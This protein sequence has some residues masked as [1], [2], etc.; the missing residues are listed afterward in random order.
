MPEQPPV[1]TVIGEALIDLVPAGGPGGY[2]AQP[3][4]SPYN[5]AI[6]LARLGRRAA[7]MARLGDNAFGRLLRGHAAAEGVD[8]DYAPDAAEPTTL[9]V[10]S[11]DDA[12]QA[13]YDFYY[14]GTADWQWTGPELARVPAD[15]AALHLGS[16]AALLPPGADRLHGLVRS[17]RA[18]AD[19]KAGAP[20]ATI[21]YDPNIRPA[22]LDTV[23]DARGRVEALIALADLV[24]LS[25]ADLAWLRPGQTPEQF[26]LEQSGGPGRIAVVTLGG[27]GAVAA[28][29]E[30][31]SH[32]LPAHSVAVVDTVGAGDSYMSALLAGLADRGL[33]GAGRR[34]ALH[35]VGPDTFRGILTQAAVAAAVTC[36]RRGSN[37]PTRAEL[38]ARLAASGALAG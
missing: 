2:T 13:S 6:G 37:P 15:T 30:A 11:V 18:G 32:R 21:S 3:G 1:I 4:G 29:P 14:A 22:L 5:V 7:L 34:A 31:G 10:V 24:K 36:E 19:G 23:T 26:V 27:Q 20:G 17:I 35:G 25:D 12:A 38:Q 8:L 28:A 9:A 33:L 16:L